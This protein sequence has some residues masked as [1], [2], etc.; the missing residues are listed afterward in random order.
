MASINHQVGISATP[1]QIY[2]FLTT[3]SGLSKWWTTDVKGAG[4]VGSL[5]EF[6]FNGGGPD[7]EVLQLI[8]NK[9][10][11]WKHSGMM[12]EAWMGTEVCFDLRVEGNQ[13]FVRFT[14]SHWQEITDFMAHCS[15]KWAVFLL[16]LKAALEGGKGKPFPNDIPIDHS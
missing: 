16:S 3:N 6:R 13:T 8:P 7:F 15:T 11:V 12:P 14:H 1:E 2:P 10:V 9:R 5:I 4:E